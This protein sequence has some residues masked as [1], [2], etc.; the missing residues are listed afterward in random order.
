MN[1]KS[2]HHKLIIYR[3]GRGRGTT[4]HGRLN[5]APRSTIQHPLIMATLPCIMVTLKAKDAGEIPS[6]KSPV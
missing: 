6:L 1:Q 5:T 3:F 2:L 4:I